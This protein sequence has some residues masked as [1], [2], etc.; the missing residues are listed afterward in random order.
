[1]PAQ[2]SSGEREFATLVDQLRALEEEIAAARRASAGHAVERHVPR[3]PAPRGDRVALAD[4]A[5]IVIRPIEPDD[6]GELA[7]G[8]DH[9]GALSRFRLFGGRVDR[10]TR[11]ELVELTQV[12]HRSSE[13]LVALDAATGEGVGI[14]RY[15]Q[16]P[17]DPA[18]AEVTCAVVDRWQHR[19]VGSALAERLCARARAAGI[20]RCTALL[21]LGNEPARRLLAHVADEIGVRRDGGTV[22]VTAQARR[23]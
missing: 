7:A 8:L 21:V 5:Q 12:D 15:D 9:L 10:P 4:G 14:A 20:E 17:G 22:D 13:M 23:R 3:E 1:M 11:R 16:M 2:L 6:V 18:R 19:G